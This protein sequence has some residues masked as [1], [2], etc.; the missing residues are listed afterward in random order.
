[1][2]GFLTITLISGISTFAIVYFLVK[3]FA[4]RTHLYQKPLIVRGYKIHHSTHGILLLVL[5]ALFTKSLGNPLSAIGLGMYLS[6]IIE[7]M[8]FNKTKATDA[9]LTFLTPVRH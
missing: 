1:M 9:I 3:P 4:K 2:F 5:G 6:H 8:Y 7:E